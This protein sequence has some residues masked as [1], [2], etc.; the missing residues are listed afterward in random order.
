MDI[1]IVHRRGLDDILGN[2]EAQEESMPTITNSLVL[3]ATN[4]ALHELDKNFSLPSL[5]S[6]KMSNSGWSCNYFAG[7]NLE[8]VETA[9]RGTQVQRNYGVD[10]SQW[11]DQFAAQ[12]F[13]NFS[14]SFEVSGAN[15]NFNVFFDAGGSAYLI[16]TYLDR[17]IRIS[18]PQSASEFVRQWKLLAGANWASAYETLFYVRPPTQNNKYTSQWVTVVTGS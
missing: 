4:D 11:P 10:P 15:H 3:A 7:A 5:S 2:T 14:M 16:Q 8:F 17:S 18:T 13:V 1:R 9:S 12:T 6:D